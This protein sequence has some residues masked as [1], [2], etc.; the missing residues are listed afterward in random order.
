MWSELQAALKQANIDAVTIKLAL[1]IA[2]LTDCKSQDL[3][4]LLA[5]INDHQLKQLVEQMIASRYSRN[6][7]TW[8]PS[9]LVSVLQRVRRVHLEQQK[10]N[11]LNSLYPTT[12]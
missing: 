11:V 1:W 3:A 2:T 6:A 10:N 12:N 9:A 5:R 4:W 8:N 7:E